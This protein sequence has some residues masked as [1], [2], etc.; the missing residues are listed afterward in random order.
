M[1]LAEIIKTL[2]AHRFATLAVVVLA[3][4]AA[5]GV[6]LTSHN[7]PT[8]AATVQILV[9]SPDS[10]LANL[11]QD[12]T[13][14]TS[15]AEVFAQVMASQVIVQNIASAAGVPA[16]QITAAGP[17]SGSGQV[18]DVV[19]PAAARSNQLLAEK[20]AYRLTF[21]AQQNTPV[22][23][24]SVQGPNAV[25]A[26][27]VAN[28]IYPGV[29]TYVSAMQQQSLTPVSQRV[30]IRQLGPAQAGTVNGG[31]RLTLMVA[32]A[33]AVL[34]L[35]TLLILGIVGIRR[36]DRE[37]A[38]IERDLAEFDAVARD[39]RPSLP[40]AAAGERH[41]GRQAVHSGPEG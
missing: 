24:A 16:A 36:R 5:A 28:A 10:Q 21:L 2:W 12:P 26:A 23:T 20:T 6:K 9:D 33:V 3:A 18:L 25:A 1:E 35:G 39:P 7:V 34:I 13:P 31:S 32:A 27:R 41:S 30:T 19:T 8:G 40:M 15:R 17:Y 37:L 22:V 14:L 11:V 38:G 29:E 4:S